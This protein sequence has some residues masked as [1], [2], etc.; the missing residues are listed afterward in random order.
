MKVPANANPGASTGP[1]RSSSGAEELIANGNSSSAPFGGI[2][3]TVASKANQPAPPAPVFSAMVT[4]AGPSRPAKQISTTRPIYPEIAKLGRIQGIV[5]LSIEVNEAG[6]VTA[7]KAVS[8]PVQL[9][10][11]AIDAARQ[12]KYEPALSNGTPIP[13]R[14]TVNLEFRLQ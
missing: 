4:S 1:D 5:V 12:W 3:P 9:R 7:A 2:L 6:K 13:A 14:L 10:E 8:G 11:A